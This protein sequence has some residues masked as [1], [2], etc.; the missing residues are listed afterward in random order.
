MSHNHGCHGAWHFKARNYP[1]SVLPQAGWPLSPYRY[2][3]TAHICGGAIQKDDEVSEENTRD[4]L[5]RVVQRLKSLQGGQISGYIPSQGAYVDS[6]GRVYS[7]G[8]L[9]S[10]YY[11]G[12]E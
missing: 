4:L 2:N 8:T 10:T 5:N 11:F 12:I 3:A 6:Q 9:G 1:E 7:G